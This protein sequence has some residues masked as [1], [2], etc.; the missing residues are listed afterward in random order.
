MRTVG[1]VL[2]L[3][4]TAQIAFA[5]PTRCECEYDDW[6]G[7][8]RATVTIEGSSVSV[9]SSVKQCSRV[10]WYLNG[11]AQLTIVTG[12]LETEEILGDP[13]TNRINVSSC[14][15]CKDAR[16]ADD[17][18]RAE[19]SANRQTP[20]CKKMME[21]MLAGGADAMKAWIEAMSTAELE[22]TQ[23]ELANCSR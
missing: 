8:C 20:A 21:L 6:V 17:D 12:G 11:N 23:R 10:D 18:Q 19:E 15:I 13:G 9:R 14:K 16:N 7:D 2:L 5:A 22:R 3:S 1:A 4:V